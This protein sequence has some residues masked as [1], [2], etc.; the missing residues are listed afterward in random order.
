M[1]VRRLKICYRH[2]QE[3]GLVNLVAFRICEDFVFDFRLKRNH[4]AVRPHKRNVLLRMFAE[5]TYNCVFDV[6]DVIRTFVKVFRFEG[7]F[8][9][10]CCFRFVNRL[11]FVGAREVVM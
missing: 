6:S 9:F 8:R 10:V 11:L 5:H 7:F 1:R 4:H 2:V 3:Y